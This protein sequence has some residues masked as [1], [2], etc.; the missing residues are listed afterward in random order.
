MNPRYKWVFGGSI[1]SC[2]EV[3]MKVAMKFY[4]GTLTIITN[5]CPFV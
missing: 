5:D 1:E 2:Y 4:D 3:A